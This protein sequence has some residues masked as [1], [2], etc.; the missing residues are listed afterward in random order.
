LKEFISTLNWVD[1]VILGCALRGA[2]VGYKEGVFAEALRFCVYGTT[3][4]VGVRF[5]S[6]LSPVLEKHFSLDAELAK[7]ASMILLYIATFL[8]LRVLALVLLKIIK[9][10]EGIIFNLLGLT[11][12]VARWAVILSI[13]FMTVQ[14]ANIQVLTQDINE[15][16]QFAK[17]IIPIAPTAYGYL[18][19]FLPDLPALGPTS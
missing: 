19:S 13:V 8:I 14:T 6:D 1:W 16:S 18:A 5:A 9:P 7:I 3:F 12:G 11:L 15:K 2:Y 10:A 4:L 17:P